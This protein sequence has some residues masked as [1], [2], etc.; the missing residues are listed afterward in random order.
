MFGQLRAQLA[1]TEKDM[2]HLRR[3]FDYDRAEKT[4]E[5]ESLRRELRAVERG[6]RDA[7]SPS[8]RLDGVVYSDLTLVEMTRESPMPVWGT[9]LGLAPAVVKR[10]YKGLV[11]GVLVTVMT[12]QSE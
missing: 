2:Q 12:E 1:Q 3:I 10:R 11:D 9:R 5:I 6:E 8:V 7:R 4:R